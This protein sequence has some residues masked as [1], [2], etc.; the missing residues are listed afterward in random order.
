[1]RRFSRANRERERAIWP[2]QE[3]KQ[4]SLN[5]INLLKMLVK[6]L[7]EKKK[8]LYNPNPADLYV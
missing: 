1:M 2:Y 8:K 6:D 3:T 4:E 7:F 5:Y